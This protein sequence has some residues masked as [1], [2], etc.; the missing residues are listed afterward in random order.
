MLVTSAAMWLAAVAALYAF[1]EWLAGAPIYPFYFVAGI[2][3][4]AMPLARVAAAPLALAWSRH[5]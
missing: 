4:L 2:A 3:I 1:L 5:R